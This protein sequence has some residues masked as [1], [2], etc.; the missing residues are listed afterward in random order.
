VAEPFAD[1]PL[2]AG[3]E[4]P[5]FRLAA[6]DGSSVELAAVLRAGPALLLFYPGNDTPGCNR[7]LGTV[8]EEIGRYRMAGVRPFGVNPA[9]PEAHREYAERLEL[10]FLLLSD[11]GLTVARRYHAVRPDAAEIDR[12]VY[13]V[14]RD[15]RV[16]FSARGAPGADIVLEGFG[17]A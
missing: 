2:P 3:A 9:T 5:P 7:Q 12:T 11:P 8:R 17:E 6:S 16:I 13:L 10:P 4:A 14:G 1:I 15:G